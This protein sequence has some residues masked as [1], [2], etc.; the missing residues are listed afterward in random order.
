MSW[1]TSLRRTRTVQV[2][3]LVLLAVCS[4]QLGYWLIDEW[5]Y[6]AGVVAQRKAAFDSQVASAAALLS[7]GVD[8]GTVAGMYPSLVVTGNPAEVRVAPE[9]IAA[10]TDARFRRLNRYAWEGAFFLA[11]LL[12][13]M[14]IVYRAVREEANLRRRQDDFL[15][16]V[17]HELQSPLA[18]M[19]LSAETLAMRDPPPARRTELIER[20]LSDLGRLQRV[21]ANILDAS[22]LAV[23]LPR[24]EPQTLE[25]GEEV[26]AV[27]GE[28]A[29]VAR[30][31]AITVTTEVGGTALMKADRQGV[32]TVIRNLMH[33]AIKAS[34]VGGGVH[35]AVRPENGQAH[36]VVSDEGMGFAPKEAGRLFEKFVRV[37][38][39]RHAISGGT[40]LGLYIVRRC[41]ELDHGS[42]RAESGG[43]G[44]GARFTVTWPTVDEAGS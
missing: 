28:L 4:A 12:A 15:A 43:V 39:E 44:R 16:T 27:L 20:L 6:T 34:S 25:L 10:V 30:E 40:G 1:R 22:R 11:V 35:V 2:G 37:E 26:R 18:S 29:D 17:S 3:F 14:A 41:V 42:V 8:R 21:I 32:Q 31:K 23:A 13:A 9:A 38:D 24:A 5:Y 7:A 36:L 19:R 33:N